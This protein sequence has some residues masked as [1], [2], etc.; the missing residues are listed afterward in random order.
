MT[1]DLSPKTLRE[2]EFREQLRGYHKDDVDDFL[3]RVAAGLETL[4]DRLREANDRV[5][6][7]ESRA[8]DRIDDDDTLK[9]TLILAQRTADLA[10]QEAQESAART[11]AGAEDEAKG[12]LSRAEATANE[13]LQQAETQL[14]DDIDRLQG[15]REQLLTEVSRLGEWMDTER[16]RLRGSLSAALAH[17][18]DA[19]PVVA[20]PPAPTP[21]EVPPAELRWDDP[22]PTMSMDIGGGGDGPTGEGAGGAD[23]EGFASEP[24][25]EGPDRTAG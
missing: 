22:E 20:S 21:V 15:T 4:L 11:L 12:L 1:L 24:I 23:P 8:V 18:E 5:V 7:L 10:I 9:R 25:G 6:R 2:V 14:R 19:I 13:M 16:E 17:I 3:E